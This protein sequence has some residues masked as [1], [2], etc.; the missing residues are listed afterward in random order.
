[1]HTA[2]LKYV[3]ISHL[4]IFCG[5]SFNG[6]S[7]RNSFE[8]VDFKARIESL[9]S[10]RL[11][12]TKLLIRYL[13]HVISRYSMDCNMNR[14]DDLRFIIFQLLLPIL[15]VYISCGCRYSKSIIFTSSG[16]ERQDAEKDRH[17]L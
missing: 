15:L 5:M 4:N 7:S 13:H 14:T 6:L 12:F 11:D 16:I 8:V 9:L 10:L 3:N 1:M 17:G 2:T